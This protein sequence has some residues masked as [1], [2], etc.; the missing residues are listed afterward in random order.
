M[1]KIEGLENLINLK[2][3]NLSNN[4]I[5]DITP[6]SFNTSLTFLDLRKN[7]KI[8]ANKENYSGE[9]LEALNKIGEILD[10]RGTIYLDTEK[11]KLFSNYTKLDL[12]SQGLTNLDCL[13]GIINLKELNLNYN[14]LTLED[15]KSKEILKSMTKLETLNIEGNCIIDLSPINE[16]KNLKTMT[17]HNANRNGN[18]N[19][20]EIEDIISNLKSFRADQN[21]INTLINCNK[22]K[23]TKLYFTN[24]EINTLPDL[25]IFP[26]LEEL[27]LAENS[28]YAN[29]DKSIIS[30]LEKIKILKLSNMH[31]KM[32]DFSKLINLKE[33]D[34]SNNRLWSEDLENLRVLKNNINL[35]LNLKNNAIIDTT[36]LLELNSNT[37]IDL[38][39]NINLSQNSKNTLKEI[40]GNNVTF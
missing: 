31:N 30:K 5:S 1:T 12:A 3:L 9:R 4:D 7:T 18:C 8:D 22:S 28:K 32:I 36:A 13:E 17:M 23:I 16:L 33:L 40:F 34:L 11:L 25:S 15:S 2:T 24:I 21:T 14:N 27:G 29:I 35:T 38:S 26:N 39:G 10:R 6:L 37:K 19:L 20:Q